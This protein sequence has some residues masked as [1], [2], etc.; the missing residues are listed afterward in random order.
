M[1]AAYFLNIITEIEK[2]HKKYSKILHKR[3]AFLKNACIIN[4]VIFETLIFK[5]IKGYEKNS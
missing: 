4:I 1:L 5:E 3:L 2:N